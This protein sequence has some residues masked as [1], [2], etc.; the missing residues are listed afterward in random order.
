MNFT[1]HLCLFIASLCLLPIHPAFASQTPEE[2]TRVYFSAAP[3]QPERVRVGRDQVLW[4]LENEFFE[5]GPCLEGVEGP[6]LVGTPTAIENVNRML[7]SPV[8]TFG[9]VRGYQ[10]LFPEACAPLPDPSASAIN[11]TNGY[12]DEAAVAALLTQFETN[13]PSLAQRIQIGFTHWGRPIWALKISD[14]VEMEEPEPRVVIDANIHANEY[15]GTEVA[16]DIIW[17]LLYGYTNNTTFASWVDGMEIY[18]IPCLNPDGR[19]YC[20]T[21]NESWRKNGRDNNHSGTMTY[22][23]DGVDLNRNSSFDWGY[24]NVGSS[25]DV[26]DYDYRG[27]SPASEP[28]IQVYDALIQRTRPAFTLSIHTFWGLFYGPYGNYDI[29][30]PAPDPFRAIGDFIAEVCTNEDNSA[31]TFVSGP[32]FGYPVNGDRADSNYGLYGIQ[33]FGVEVGVNKHQPDYSTV[34]L[35]KL[36]P[37]VRLGW[38][39]FLAA[40]H[41]N[42]PKVLGWSLDTATGQPAPVRIHSLNL[43]NR[44][45]DEHWT[46][47]DD[48]YFECPLPT[49]GTYR[50]V[51]APIGQESL[52]TTQ[53]LVVSSTALTADQTFD[54]APELG[55]PGAGRIQSWTNQQEDGLVL[56]E[57]AD[58]PT[59]PWLPFL[60][61]S[62]T[63]RTGQAE[64]PDGFTSRVV[65]V[66]TSP[67]Y[68]PANTN[69]AFIPSGAF[70]M[71]SDGAI[72]L[73]EAPAEAIHLEGFAIDCTEVTFAEWTRVRLWAIANGYFFAPG[74]PGVGGASTTN[75]PVLVVTWYD[76]IKWCNAR[77]QSEGLLP[78]YYSTAAQTN[79][80][81]TGITNLSEACVNWQAN[82]YRLPT[83]AEWEKAARGGSTGIDYPWGDTLAMSNANYAA[84]GTTLTGA[85]PANGYGLHDAAGNAAEWCWDW[86]G[87]YTNRANEN[88]TGPATGTA[89]IVRGGSWSDAGSGLRCAARSYLAPASSNTVVGLR[90][91]RK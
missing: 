43:T 1:S 71:G 46:S 4:R 23:T 5:E 7:S 2:E 77:S 53:A 83:E 33:A 59:G 65:R 11:I 69:M 34:T 22:G 42:W 12:H 25:P 24:D 27:P 9:T 6:I 63:G 86:S 50:V 78:A 41:T 30:M 87:S 36:V 51:F 35:P 17:Q 16:L 37:G 32:E 66:R 26:Y 18:V 60:A 88:P 80:Y 85:Y 20:D 62:C 19:Y 48:G 79:I 91:V 67:Q 58:S 64:I 89:R 29:A 45:N 3:A 81:K 82:G 44:P 40:A 8:Q 55:M 72:D 56:L 57:A 52:S 90:C 68:F 49:A 70:L 14:N 39:R 31:Y 74:Q 61:Q 10:E 73:S 84:T 54:V 47:R 38:Q 28:E 75:H 13:F 76:A 15:P 21:V